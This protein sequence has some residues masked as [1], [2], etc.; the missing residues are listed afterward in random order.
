[1]SHPEFLKQKFKKAGVQGA[2]ASWRGLGCPQNS[3]YFFYAPPAAARE[4]K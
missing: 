1:M 4:K 3:F 2:A